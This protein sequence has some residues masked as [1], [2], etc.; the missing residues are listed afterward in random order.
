MFLE[1]YVN[2][3][4]FEEILDTYEEIYLNNLDENNFL[5]VLQVLRKYHFNFIEDIILKYLEI[6]EMDYNDVAN[7]LESLKKELGENFVDIIG[8]DMSYLSKIIDD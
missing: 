3:F 2:E 5:E 6:F 7:N 1:K 4:Y 8:N